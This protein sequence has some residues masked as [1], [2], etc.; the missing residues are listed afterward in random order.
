MARTPLIRTMDRPL[1]IVVGP[2]V[3]HRFRHDRDFGLGIS[4]EGLMA[5]FH[6]RGRVRREAMEKAPMKWRGVAL[7]LSLLICVSLSGQV[8]RAAPV[9][10]TVAVVDFFAPTPLGPYGVVPERFAADSLSMLLTQAAAGRFVVVPRTAITQV[11]TALRWENFDD[12]NF[13]RLRALAGA[14][15][16]DSL[17]VGWIQLLAVGGGGGDAGP[18]AANAVLLIQIFDV[19]QNIVVGQTGQAESAMGATTRDLLVQQVLHDA[20][21]R[22]VPFAVGL[23]AT[24]SP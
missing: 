2:E 17:V 9:T 18:Q 11:E 14:V 19:A 6:G 13:A 22:A 24:G 4:M 5:S 12:L 15:G 20:M 16:A 8:S 3:H 10:R 21:V 23:L 1:E 7:V